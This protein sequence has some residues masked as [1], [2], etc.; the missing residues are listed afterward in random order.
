MHMYRDRRSHAPAMPSEFESGGSGCRG[1]GWEGEGDG[2]G[3]AALEGVTRLR[4]PSR[5][6]RLFWMDRRFKVDS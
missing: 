4:R 5:S 6:Q 3:V 2:K 1:G